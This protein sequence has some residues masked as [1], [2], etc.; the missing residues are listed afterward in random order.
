MIK[1]LLCPRCVAVNVIGNSFV[2][3][4]DVT[5][6]VSSVKKSLLFNMWLNSSCLCSKAQN[7]SEHRFKVPL[8]RRT[9]LTTKT[10]IEKPLVF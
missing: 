10:G 3:L 7:K 6:I 9:S 1:L 5:S 8:K 4:E 2:Y